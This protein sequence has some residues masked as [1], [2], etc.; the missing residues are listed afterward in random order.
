MAQC[1]AQNHPTGY[2]VQDCPRAAPRAKASGPAR[3][4]SQM[5]S[6]GYSSDFVLRCSVFTLCDTVYLFYVAFEAQPKQELIIDSDEPL[7]LCVG[8]CTSMQSSTKQ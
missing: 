2:S 1:P 4:T 5:E 8:T 6:P 7:L 3:G